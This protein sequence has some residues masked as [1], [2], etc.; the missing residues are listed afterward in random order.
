MSRFPPLYDITHVP[1]GAVLV[2]A[3]HP[4]DEILGCGGAI[5]LHVR[6]GDR[7]HVA[8]ATQGEGGGDPLRRVE[9]SRAAAALLGRTEVCSLGA[10]DGHVAQDKG[11]AERLVQVLVR[12]R[13]HVVYAPSP[14]EQHPDHLAALAATARALELARLPAKLLLYEVNSEGLASFLL[15]ITPV[16]AQKREAL[17][18]FASQLGLVDLVDKCD[19]RARARTVNVDLPAVTHAEGY[20]ELPAARVADALERVDALRHALGLAL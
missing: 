4:D 6:R 3:P 17:T 15:D 11:L 9:E 19:A 7:V 10:R 18:A 5:V 2:V 14:F 8:L 20:L 12:V 1:G 16:A 13:P